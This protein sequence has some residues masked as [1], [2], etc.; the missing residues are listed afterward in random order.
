MTILLCSTLICPAAFSQE[1]PVSVMTLADGTPVSMTPAQLAALATKPGITVTTGT[2]AVGATQMAVPLPAA[3]GGGFIVAEPAALAAGLNAVG[4][5]TG[6][7]ATTVAGA[8]AGAG[9]IVAG[10][11][12]AGAATAGGISAGTVGLIGAGAAAVAGGIA[13]AGGGGGGGGTTTTH[14]H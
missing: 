4:L 8:T 14:H 5:T 9:G 13:A 10:A 7:T 1:V 6:A 3:L 2:P 12:V 11:S